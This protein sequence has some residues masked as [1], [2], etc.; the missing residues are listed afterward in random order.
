MSSLGSMNATLKNN[1]A[2]LLNSRKRKPFNSDL[3]G[4]SREYT[5]RRYVHPEIFPHVL[6]RIRLKM[7]RQN[8]RLFRLKLCVAS[9]VLGIAFYLLYQLHF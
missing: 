3:G 7:K 4:Y 2:L 5:Y 8:R 1:R 6:R 9:F